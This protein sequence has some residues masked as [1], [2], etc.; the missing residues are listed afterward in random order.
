[1]MKIR[2]I[3]SFLKS[4]IWTIDES[5]LNPLCRISLTALRR[6]VITVEC[7]VKN[8][9]PSYASALTYSCIL[10]AVP[11]L[12]IVFA[13]AR[14]F[15]FG[16][17]IEVSI[18]ENV[19]ADNELVDSVFDFIDHYLEHTH[20]GV[21]LGV[22][23]L[24]LLYTVVMLTS[25]IE[26]AFNTIWHVRSSRDLPRQILNYAAIFLLFPLL[27]VVTSGFSVFMLT[28]VDQLREYE[29]LSRTMELAIKYTPMLLA[30][31][32]FVA[33]YKF[34]PNTHVKWRAVVVPGFI[35]GCLFLVLQYFYIHYQLMLSSYNAIYGSFAA[36]PLFML[37]IQFSWY[38]CLACAQLSYA[39]QHDGD[40][41][42][43]K[44]S[45][46]LSRLEHDTLCLLLMSHTVRQFRNGNPP[47][48]VHRLSLDTGL[49][50]SLVQGLMDELVAV[51][52]LNELRG[53]AGTSVH[54]QPSIDTGCIT[55]SYVLRQLDNR[56]NGHISQLWAEKNTEWQ[57]LLQVR[58]SL[59]I[60]DG[61]VCVADILV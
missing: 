4:G 21:F 8:N 20:S 18:R 49:P 28:I 43:A 11:V 25:N 61:D 54:Y 30:C 58:S 51:G 59:S 45:N 47:Y 29:V 5:G 41:T 39:S 9:L 24:L 52:L 53:D 23:L 3:R 19:S 12:S 46:H 10:A 55:V 50:H 15:G 14:G 38:I 6:L 56:D 44:D 42:F 17:L 32:C 22:G 27:I 13:V 57:H 33:L 34:M 60:A 2:E 1:M 35:A 37:W 31:L 16:T 40:Y 26:T 36:L 7:F 48:S